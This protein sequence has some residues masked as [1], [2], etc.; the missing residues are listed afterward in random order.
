MSKQ[1][2]QDF[3]LLDVTPKFRQLKPGF[4]IITLLFSL[5]LAYAAYQSWQVHTD[6]KQLAA[7]ALQLKKTSASTLKSLL[8]TDTPDN[9]FLGILQEKI[10]MNASGFSNIFSALASFHVP[11]VWLYQV[12][13]N[14]PQGVIRVVGNALESEPIFEFV[15]IAKNQP[16]FQGKEFHIFRVEQIT[17]GE[18]PDELLASLQKQ[19]SSKKKKGRKRKK[20]K[21]KKG[22]VGEDVKHKIYVFALQTKPL[23][24]SE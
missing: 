5:T 16:E 3:N 20:A 18:S 1:R 19:A 7:Q 23:E 10:H 14:S 8:S 6:N 9:P 12:L 4:L 22:A 15:N 21:K 2:P 17:Y 11:N 24:G 13:L